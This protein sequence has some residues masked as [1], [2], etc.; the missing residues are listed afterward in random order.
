MMKQ[1]QTGDYY[2]ARIEAVEDYVFFAEQPDWKIMTT[3]LGLP[4]PAKKEIEVA[5]IFGGET[6]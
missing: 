2:R 4:V 6:K 5:P 3:I 1:N